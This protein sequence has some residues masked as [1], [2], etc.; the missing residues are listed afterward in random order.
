M[1]KQGN[2]EQNFDWKLSLSNNRLN[3]KF[4][5]LK[6]KLRSSS[7]VAETPLK[8]LQTNQKQGRERNYNL[9]QSKRKSLQLQDEGSDYLLPMDKPSLKN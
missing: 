1:K 8:W 2:P 7:E 3:H 4:L 9:S 5:L 6:T